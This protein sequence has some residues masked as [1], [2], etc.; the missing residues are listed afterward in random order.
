ML[1][2]HHT[3]M[4]QLPIFTLNSLP[5]I[6]SGLN[7]GQRD[8]LDALWDQHVA[9]GTPF[10]KRRLPRVIGKQTADEVVTGLLR[11]LLIETHEGSDRCYVLKARGA[12]LSSSGPSLIGLFVRLLDLVK[13][14]YD[15]NSEL[16]QLDNKTIERALE[17]SAAESRQ[18][19]SFVRLADLPEMPFYLSGWSQ[20]GATWHLKITDQVLDL[21]L[22][23]SSTEFLNERLV[24]PEAS[25]LVF[26]TSHAFPLGEWAGVDASL[27][28]Q[29]IMPPWAA[30][31]D[32]YVTQLRLETLNQ[33]RHPA[34]D[35]TRL[36]SMCLEL[37]NC[38]QHANTHAVIMLTRAILD[39]V[40]PAFDHATF[41]EVASNY[42]GGKSL[43]KALER[44]E[45]HSR[46]V[47]DRLL[48]T[49]IRRNE[50]APTMKEVNFS[51]ELEMVLA[52]FC[53]LLKKGPDDRNNV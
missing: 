10:P 50:V 3:F 42:S 22:A 19:F 12:L 29:P 9:Q 7:T 6:V 52:E 45:N 11:Y 25:R 36:I 16:A 20:D 37:N 1:I 53:R 4:L 15:E 34:F 8:L 18:V 30:V 24:F 38:A 41:K 13:K 35:C 26:G 28:Q 21:Y 33:V 47:A 43:K 39:H 48:H 51:A 46:T 40:A 23:P 14:L 17:L 44:L 2:S 32:A 31:Q 27:S 49:P 5:E